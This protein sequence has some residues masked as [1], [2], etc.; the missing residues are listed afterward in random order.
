MAPRTSSRSIRTRRPSG[1]RSAQLGRASR[2]TSRYSVSGSAHSAQAHA[3]GQGIDWFQQKNRGHH[4]LSEVRIAPSILSADFLK[5]GSELES[6]KTA[7][8]IHFDVMDGM[9]VPNLSFGPGI[10]S[11]VKKATDLPVD[12]H[13]MIPSVFGIVWNEGGAIL[14][15]GRNV[16]VIISR[17]YDVRKDS[18]NSC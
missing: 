17:V 10:L 13:L 18:Q 14:F 15:I 12:V 1:N 4:M 9:F 2:R 11:Q 5:L 16:N 6:I 7:D 8:Y 3:T